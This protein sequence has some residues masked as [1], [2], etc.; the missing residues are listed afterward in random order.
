MGGVTW[1]F[2]KLRGPILDLKVVRRALFIRTPTK[3]A[4]PIYGISN[5]ESPFRVWPT[6]PAREAKMRAQKDQI[7]IR[8]LIWYVIFMYAMEYGIW[9][10]V[11][12]PRY[13][14]SKGPTKHNMACSIW[15]TAMVGRWY[16]YKQKDLTK[17]CFWCPFYI[18]PW[19]QNARSLCLRGLL[20]PQGG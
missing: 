6:K 4:H 9:Y 16:K 18:G 20:G 8:I 13:T 1:E 19:N 17:Q 14:A 15:Y 12:S 5:L 11:Y 2:P 7:N 10:R 3:R